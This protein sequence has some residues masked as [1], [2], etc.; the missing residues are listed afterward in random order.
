MNLTNFVQNA[1]LTESD[2]FV[3]I[4]S[5]LSP[6]RNI[7]LTH[8]AEGMVTEIAELVECLRKKEFDKVNFMEENADILWY[9]AIACHE[10][11][12]KFSHM[13]LSA[14]DKIS[15][16][17]SLLKTI[18]SKLFLKSVLQEKINDSIIASGTC[19]DVM[20]KTTFYSNKVFDS[21]KFIKHLENQ[22]K[23]V[24]EMLLLLD[25]NVEY[26]C[27]RVIHKL[28]KVRYKL[29]KFTPEEALE[30][31]LEQE[32]KSLENKN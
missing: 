20:K 19:L 14:Y 17:S 22:I 10:L 4:N 32:R 7:R 15:K 9:I 24:A 2:D 29:G 6:K 25:Y 21:E 13:V 3:S 30:R 8:A 31:N 23:A 16:E 18:K 12:L 28:Q 11:Y 27:E 5:R 26:G 1:I